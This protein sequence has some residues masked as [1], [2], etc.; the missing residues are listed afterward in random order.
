MPCFSTIRWAWV[1]LP[2]PGGPKRYQSHRPLFP[3]RSFDFLIRPFILLGN[4][5][6]LNLCYRIKGYADHDQKRSTTKVE[7]NAGLGDQD[8]GQMQTKTR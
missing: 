5:V 4:Q 8:F 2:A 6:T 7:G 1:P 3:P